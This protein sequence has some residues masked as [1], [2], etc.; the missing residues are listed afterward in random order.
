MGDLSRLRLVVGI[1]V[2]LLYILVSLGLSC[3]STGVIF[4]LLQTIENYLSIHFS[5]CSTPF[6]LSTFKR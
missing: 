6:L 1:Q 5:L 4:L 2:Y 3:Y